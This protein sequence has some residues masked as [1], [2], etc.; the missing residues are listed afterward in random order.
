MPK[1]P[2]KVTD[3]QLC[4]ELYSNVYPHLAWVVN[5]TLIT[6]FITDLADLLNFSEEI[7][8]SHCLKY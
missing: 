6:S 3:L 8:F 7:V 2:Q 5:D 1:T 4:V